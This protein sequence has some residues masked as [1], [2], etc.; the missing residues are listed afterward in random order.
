MFNHQH[1]YKTFKQQLHTLLDLTGPT[2]QNF[3]L[4]QKVVPPFLRAS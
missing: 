3:F 4:R 1:S 2:M